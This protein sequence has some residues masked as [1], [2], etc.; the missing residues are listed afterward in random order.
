[1]A[2][3]NCEDW[4]VT[5]LTEGGPAALP[6]PLV[7]AAL[8]TAQ[9]WLRSLTGGV[10]GVCTYNED[11]RTANSGGCFPSPYKDA[12]GNW[13]NNMGDAHICCSIALAHT[14]VRKI[15]AVYVSG[16]I[17]DPSTYRVERGV[18]RRLGA[19]WPSVGE[20]DA[21]AISVDY[22]AGRVPDAAA[23]VA[24]GALAAEIAAGMTGSECHLPDTVLSVVRQGVTY[25][26]A[27]P[28]VLATARRTGVSLVDQ[29]VD[30]VNP[31]RRRSRPTVISPD[32]TARVR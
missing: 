14:P 29:W 20:C 10:Y 16:D 2:V 6:E 5:W 25:Q 7:E 23:A 28:T 18:L 19:C 11:Y 17:L 13:R 9:V 12:G 8:A 4:P 3:T 21:A 31:S 27:D 24:M 15:N 30:A 32:M 26:F 22:S 1:M